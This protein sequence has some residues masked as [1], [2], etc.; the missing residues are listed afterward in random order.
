MCIGG[1]TNVRE[2]RLSKSDKITSKVFKIARFLLTRI[3]DF[4]QDIDHPDKG[5]RGFTQ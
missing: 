4:R 5:V 1:S 2:L 3:Y